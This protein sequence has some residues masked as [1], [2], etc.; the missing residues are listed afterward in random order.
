MVDSHQR[1]GGEESYDE[2]RRICVSVEPA[3][4]AETYAER[5]P[6]RS[7]CGRE[8]PSPAGAAPDEHSADN[9][10]EDAKQKNS[11]D[12]KRHW[13]DTAPERSVVVANSK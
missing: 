10:D 6:A 11:Y 8:T 3:D 9:A 12:V 4:G 5:G 2:G 13:V 1:K 7:T